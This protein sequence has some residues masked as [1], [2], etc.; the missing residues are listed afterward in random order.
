MDEL[1]LT[2]VVIRT[3]GLFTGESTLYSIVLLLLLLLLAQV[4]YNQV[5]PLQI[6]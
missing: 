6:N 4:T 2:K 1:V 5:L 3:S